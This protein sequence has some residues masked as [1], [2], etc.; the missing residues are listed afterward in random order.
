[1]P[2][3]PFG[4][5]PASLPIAGTLATAT[6][7]AYQSN[8]TGDTQ[9]RLT[10]D[11]SGL[12]LWGSGAAVGDIQLKR[13]AAQTLQLFS[14]GSGGVPPVLSLETNGQSANELITI[15]LK[16]QFYASNGTC[17]IQYRL[18][19]GGATA[20]LIFGTGSTG[21]TN[22]Q[23]LAA[24]TG[25]VLVGAGSTPVAQ[26]EVRTA[27][28]ATVGTYFKAATSQSVDISQ[29][30]TSTG[31]LRSG[32]NSGGVPYSRQG[33]T[34]A[35]STVAL[36]S[37]AAQVDTT[38]DRYVTCPITFNPSGVAAATL[39]VELSPDNATYSTLVTKN[40]PALAA[41][42][43]LVDEVYLMVPKAWY[44]RLTPVNATI[45]TA[46]YY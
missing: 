33:I 35:L 24:G 39:Q 9:Q 40:A 8:V 20:D 17:K 42:A 19:A 29:I 31:G 28:A 10:I 41:L 38:A 5:A 13:S 16:D 15:Q 1:M 46:T 34:G 26:L 25:G 14:G 11:A 36:S 27:A 37:T 4:A 43:G 32:V 2:L 7:N 30:A 3:L 21:A 6:T 23:L 22:Q 44:V 45:G 12:M 18:N